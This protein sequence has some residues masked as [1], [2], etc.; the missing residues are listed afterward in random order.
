MEFK[1]VNSNYVSEAVALAI[2]EGLQKMWT[3]NKK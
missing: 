2:L 3:I 1:K